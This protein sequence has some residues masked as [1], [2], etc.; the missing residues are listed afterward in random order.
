MARPRRP[1][2]RATRLPSSPRSRVWALPGRAPLVVK[3]AGPAAL[4]REAAALRALAGLGVAPDLV[5]T[6]PG[7]LVTRRLPG[8]VRQAAGLGPE[9][10]RALGRAVRR[11]HERRRT[12]TGGLPGWPRRVRTLAAYHRGRALDTLALATGDE[13]DL[14]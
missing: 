6:A 8:A 9:H 5:A 12:A 3:L 13:R 11:A 4:R 7:V 14:A 10:L 1:A 2:G